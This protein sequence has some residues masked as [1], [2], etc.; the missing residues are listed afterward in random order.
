M[1]DDLPHIPYEIRHA[2]ET[3]R[4]VVFAGAGISIDRETSAL[5]NFTELVCGLVNPTWCPRENI[6]DKDY[7]GKNGCPTAHHK[8]LCRISPDRFLGRAAENG[9]LIH[10]RCRDCFMTRQA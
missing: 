4:L 6:D 3:G 5:P 2:A 10:H 1:D 8:S 9:T 7:T